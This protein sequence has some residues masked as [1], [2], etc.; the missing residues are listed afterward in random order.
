M[1]IFSSSVSLPEG[2]FPISSLVGP[3]GR[4]RPLRR[5]HRR[6]H[7]GRRSHCTLWRRCAR[8]VSLQSPLEDSQG[9]NFPL[10]N[11]E[12]IGLGGF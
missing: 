4:Q 12:I 6:H 5:L 7:H 10:K 11:M 3:F 8:G 2:H 9:A 1:V